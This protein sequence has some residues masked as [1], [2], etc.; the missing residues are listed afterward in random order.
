MG[1]AGFIRDQVLADL[2]CEV[3]QDVVAFDHSMER[4]RRGEPLV[5]GRCTKAWRPGGKW[6]VAADQELG[7]LCAESFNE[8]RDGRELPEFRIAEDADVLLFRVLR[9]LGQGPGEAVHA[10]D[11]WL[12]T[13][14]VSNVRNERF[15]SVDRRIEIG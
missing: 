7:S 14:L 4:G 5:I 2:E 15:Q 13:M 9:V 8:S 1:L 12:R 6:L 11:E 10:D 3:V